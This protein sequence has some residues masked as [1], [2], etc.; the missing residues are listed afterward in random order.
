[1]IFLFWTRPAKSAIPAPGLAA[2]VGP[3]TGI[4]PAVVLTRTE[5]HRTTLEG[6]E[7]FALYGRYHPTFQDFQ[8]AIP[9]VLDALP[10]RYSQQSV[11]WMT[12][13][14]SNSMTSHSWPRK[15]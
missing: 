8:A 10:T 2:Q 14:S 13:I 9:E 4:V 7:A 11:S 12:R 1:M 6:H 3:G 5:P 15:V